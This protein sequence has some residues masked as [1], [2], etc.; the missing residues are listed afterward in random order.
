RIESVGDVVDRTA[1]EGRPVDPAT[2][3]VPFWVSRGSGVRFVG[4]QPR[5][6]RAEGDPGPTQEYPAPGCRGHQTRSPWTVWASAGP[7]ACVLAPT[8]TQSGPPNGS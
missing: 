6:D 1:A 3:C 4:Q 8:C 2:V 7:S 5:G